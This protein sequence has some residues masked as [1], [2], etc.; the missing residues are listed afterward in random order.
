L[1]YK[2]TN[3]QG[4]KDMNKIAEL[5]SKTGF[6]TTIGYDF[7]SSLE[8]LVEAGLID[9]CIVSSEDGFSP[10]GAAREFFAQELGIEEN[11]IRKIADWNRFHNEEVSFA[12][13]P[14]RNLSSKLRGVILAAGET[15]RCYEKFAKPFYG[16]PYRDFYYDVAYESIAYSAFTLGAKKIAITHLSASQHFHEDIA[17][18]IAEAL[19]HF[20]DNKDNPKIDSF[21]FAGCCI[22]ETHLHG[23]K[24][25]NIEGDVSIHRNVVTKKY[26]KDGFEIVSLDLKSKQCELA[27]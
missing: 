9:C 2:T 26:S 11:K 7:E 27:K 5:R 6:V 4:R 23:I 3:L 15:S 1:T 25:L 16:R 13:L 22:E 21:I 17:T 8:S 14:S 18:C 19:A 12:A 20:C 10:L 24:R